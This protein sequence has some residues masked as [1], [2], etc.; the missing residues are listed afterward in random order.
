MLRSI[1]LLFINKLFK[2]K[3]YILKEL[4][5]TEIHTKIM[6]VV[7]Y[8]NSKSVITQE[9]INICKIADIV[10]ILDRRTFHIIITAINKVSERVIKSS[11]KIKLKTNFLYNLNCCTQNKTDFMLRF[12][13]VNRIG[14]YQYDFKLEQEYLTLK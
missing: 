11:T 13:V 12:I 14:I 8:T 6:K 4:S 2:I 10:S 3:F 5:I 7:K 9:I 1:N